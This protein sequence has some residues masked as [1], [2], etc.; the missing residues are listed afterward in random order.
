MLDGSTV[1][2]RDQLR[3][4]A[5]HLY[6]DAGWFALLTASTLAFIPIYVARLGATSFQIGIISAGPAVVNLF[7]SLPAGRWLVGIRLGRATFVSSLL[8]RCVYAILATLPFMTGGAGQVWVV[9]LLVLTGSIPGTVMAIAFNS[10]FAEV[11]P[12][13]ERSRIVGR[14]NAL[15]SFG[16]VMTSLLCGWLL[17]GLVYPIN[18]GAVFAIGAFGGLMSSLH[19]MQVR[20]PVSKKVQP[21][22]WR[23][24]GDA[25]R[26]G[27]FRLDIGGVLRQAPGL[28][29]LS[30]PGARRIS[31]QDVLR[32]PFGAFLTAYLFF[33][34]AQYVPIPLFPVYWLEGLK[35]SESTLSV[36]NAIFYAAMLG[37]S[38]ALRP[39]C[40]W[41]GCRR[42]LWVSALF[43]G[44]YPLLNGLARDAKMFLVASAVGGGV[45]A[46]LGGALISR[47]ME[48]VPHEDR[49]AHMAFHNLAL[50]L[51]I[52]AGSMVG[53]MLG[54]ILG[55]REALYLSAGLRLVAALCLGVWA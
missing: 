30:R 33:Y 8:A 5:R 3:A 17:S 55:P 11:V 38:L 41:Y 47:L 50:N 4:N 52:L 18:Y 13:E 40:K 51:G 7:F 22:V 34:V 49:S 28:R 21:R 14:R 15:L 44:L 24:L 42:V 48:R 53:P 9:S 43:Y 19:L 12:Q 46:I 39:L 1:V 32:T 35:L 20:L 2:S 54:A 27:P 26:P 6:A 37:A 23:P 25:A 45:W 16:L 10:L 29:L 31:P 36:G